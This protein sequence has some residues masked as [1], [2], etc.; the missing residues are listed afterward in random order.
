MALLT[1]F[2]FVL[3]STSL[4]FAQT[5]GVKTEYIPR[6]T[7]ITPSLVSDDHTAEGML[8]T[9]SSGRIIHIFRLD[10]GLE[11]N[12]VGNNARIVKR[13]SDDDGETWSS[14]TTIV[15]SEWDDRNV[16]GGIVGDDRI[17]MFFRKYD[18]NNQLTK[19]ISTIYSDD[20]GDTWSQEKPVVTGGI[21]SGTHKI[22][23]VPGKGFLG[24]FCQRWYVE[25]KFSPDGLEWDSTIYK[26]DYLQNKLHNLSETCFSYVG[27]GKIIGLSR[28]CS[29]GFGSNYY[30]LQS[31]NYGE[32]WEE[33]VK[34]NI[35]DSFFCPSPFIFYDERH[36]HLWSIA[37]DRRNYSGFQFLNT[38]SE[39]YVYLNK[40]DD[41]ISNPTNYSL[42]HRCPRPFPNFYRFYGYAVATKKSNGDYLV[43]I[44]ESYRKTNMYEQADFYQF[45]INYEEV[46]TYEEIEQ[47]QEILSLGY[48]NPATDF[49]K[50]YYHAKLGELDNDL[51]FYLYKSDG[52]LIY[53]EKL[54]AVEGEN[55][56]IL[57]VNQFENG[58]YY[59][60]INNQNAQIRR[61]LI[62]IK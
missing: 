30:H 32:T 58:A 53:S 57:N 4:V 13:V 35:V 42:Y 38:N 24:M 59:Y 15:D 7:E 40:P 48:P 62:V 39:V 10:P 6:I 56:F 46:I 45:S 16:H 12:H 34:S 3:L 22:V 21:T 61:R 47:Q 31:T 44:T 5:K 18:A 43:I 33:P 60:T 36:D 25:V 14:L 27:N 8:V 37:T 51:L 50:I 20:G 52:N 28:D 49:T 1:A 41:I 23:E 19:S 55:E 26:F 2:L 54:Y 29:E 9:L 11:G 17:V